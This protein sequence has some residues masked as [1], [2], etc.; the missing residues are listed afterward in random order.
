[1]SSGEHGDVKPL[2]ASHRART[3]EEAGLKLHPN[4]TSQK[5]HL[6]IINMQIRFQTKTRFC[7]VSTCFPKIF[8]FRNRIHV[9]LV[10]F[11]LFRPSRL[12]VKVQKTRLIG[13]M[14]KGDTNTGMSTC[15]ML[16]RRFSLYLLQHRKASVLQLPSMK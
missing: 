1:M 6:Y 11:L 8:A 16:H 12:F 9:F 14:V 10:L 15:S 4:F 3:E 5:R 2:T 13:L 7:H